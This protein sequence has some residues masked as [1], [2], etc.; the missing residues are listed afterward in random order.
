[1]I[2]AAIATVTIAVQVE[3]VHVAE[4]PPPAEP[5]PQIQETQEAEDGTKVYK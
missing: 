1:M 2:L 4:V 5:T 3:F